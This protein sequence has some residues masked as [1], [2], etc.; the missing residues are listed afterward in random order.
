MNK[1]LYELSEGLKILQKYDPDAQIATETKKV[2]VIIRSV[3]GLTSYDVYR[4]SQLRWT[5]KENV[6]WLKL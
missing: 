1:T 6:F 2:Q 3:S 5:A 4:L